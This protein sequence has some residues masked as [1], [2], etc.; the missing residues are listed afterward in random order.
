[1]KVITNKNKTNINMHPDI[2]WPILESLSESGLCAD[3][4]DDG[5]RLLRLRR[6]VVASMATLLVARLT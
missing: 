2:S 5:L 1:M 6:V 4:V 3:A